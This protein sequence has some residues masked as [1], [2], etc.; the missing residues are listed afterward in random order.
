M[1]ILMA[2]ALSACG[3]RASQ[4]GS[5]DSDSVAV[6]SELL[7]DSIGMEREDSMASVTISVDWP[8][9]GNDS[10][11]QAIHQYICEALAASPIQE[12]QPEVTLYD[13]GQK[14]VEA[15][16]NSRYQELKSNWLEIKGEGYPGMTFSYY[17]HVFKLEDTDRYVTYETNSEG[18]MGGAHGFASAMSTTFRKRDGLQIGYTTEYDQQ[19]ETFVLKDQTLFKDP[20]SQQLA[21]L[22]KEGV[23]SYFKEFDESAI[24]DEQLKDLLIGVD[25]I[26]HIPLPSAAPSFTKQG[27]SFVYQQY[28]IAP[29]A[30]GMINFNIPYKKILPFLT[31]DAAELVPQND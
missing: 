23:R 25:D 1:T 24:N 7:T 10:L 12:G 6:A 5:T 2:A 27:L 15:T 26:D 18:F 11:V 28:E 30:A 13:D 21:K 29:Y 3:H 31:D 8:K 4:Q 22:I 9:N 19:T 20:K 16:V 17:L 14:A